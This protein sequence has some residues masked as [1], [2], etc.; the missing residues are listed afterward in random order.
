MSNNERA[1]VIML[2]FAF[3]LGIIVGMS[4]IIVLGD[5]GCV[6]TYSFSFSGR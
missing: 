6:P 3:A 4:V 1:V 5:L 2:L